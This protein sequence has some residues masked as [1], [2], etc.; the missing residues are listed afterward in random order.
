MINTLLDKFKVTNDPDDFALF[1]IKDTGEQ[2]RVL[3][4][5]FPLVTRILNGPFEDAA[6]LFICDKRDRDE[7]PFEV[8]LCLSCFIVDLLLC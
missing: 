7:I 8:S 3:D 1:I 4:H 6:R 5:E 2:R